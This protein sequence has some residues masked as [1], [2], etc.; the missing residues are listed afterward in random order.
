[1]RKSN[2]ASIFSNDLNI[3]VD[4]AAGV[5]SAESFRSPLAPDWLIVPNQDTGRWLQIKL[6]DRLGSLANTKVT[7]LTEFIWS[8]SDAQPDKQFQSDLY[9]AIAT[10]WRQKY[11]DLAE[12]E[13]LQQVSC[14]FELFQNYLAERPDWLTNPEKASSLIQ[15]SSVWQIALWREIEPLLPIAPHRK[16]YR[17]SERTQL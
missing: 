15:Q 7:T 8:I 11:P 3:L 9:W 1:M 14:L 17:C 16:A 5:L 6:T 4:T 12:P 10:V 13:Y 2:Y